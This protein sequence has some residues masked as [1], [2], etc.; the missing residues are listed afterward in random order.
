VL[1]TSS[2]DAKL[3][4][5]R[6]LGAAAGANYREAGWAERIGGVDLVVDSVGGEA[7]WEGALACLSRGGRLVNFADTAGDHGRVLLAR[8]FLEHQRIIG[9]TL[10]SPREFDAL[11]AHCGE[12]TWR[13]VVDSVFPLR[14]AAAAHERLDAPDRFGKVVL[15]VD[16]ARFG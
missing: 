2:S 12:A 4:R 9:T 6:Q 15:A 11:L 13:P 14:D 7:V 3:E 16:Q 5:A 8:L 10:G 1:V